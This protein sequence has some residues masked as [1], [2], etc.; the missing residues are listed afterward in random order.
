MKLSAILE[1]LASSADDLC[2]V[3]RRPWSADADALLVSF[4]DDFGIPREVMDSGYEYFLETS[5]L[6]DEVLGEWG[7][8]MSIDER[9]AIAIYYAEHDAWP[10]WF[11][12]D[13]QQR[14]RGGA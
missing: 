4:T 11:H 9:T 2:I 12:A 3:A 7:S 8:A 13:V 1:N 14:P 5:T 6:K 10:A